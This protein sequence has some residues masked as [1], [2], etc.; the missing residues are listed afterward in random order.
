M[1]VSP[2]AIILFGSRARGDY[3][4]D[5]DYDFLIISDNFKEM[6]FFDR[7]RLIENMWNENES[8]GVLEVF[9]YTKKEFLELLEKKNLT[10]LDGL[11]DGIVLYADES[12]NKIKEIYD[13]MKR[14]R[15][16]YKED[17]L[18]KF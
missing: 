12:F 2:C 15:I 18:W 13:E 14:D 6:D 9:P 5:S 10:A 8:F 7:I 3:L 4:N 11:E 1:D 16:I 17:G